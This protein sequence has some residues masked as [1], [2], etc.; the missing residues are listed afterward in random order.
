M[1]AGIKRDIISA[2]SLRKPEAAN[3]R[4]QI[5]YPLQ[6]HLDEVKWWA[7]QIVG[8]LTDAQSDIAKAVIVA[9][10]CH[11]LEASCALATEPRQRRLS[12]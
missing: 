6:P 1:Q 4:S 12:Q 5:A 9:A 7:A 2:P 10:W 11:D 3:E 8:R